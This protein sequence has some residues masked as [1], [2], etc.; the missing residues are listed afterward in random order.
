MQDSRDIYCKEPVPAPHRRRRRSNRQP[1][2]E[3]SGNSR[4]R[5]PTGPVPSRSNRLIIWVVVIGIG[6]VYAAFLVRSLLHNL[7]WGKDANKTTVALNVSPGA[8]VTLET[9]T[10]TQADQWARKSVRLWAQWNGLMREAN[11]LVK[12]GKYDEAINRLEN[13]AANKPFLV[14]INLLLGKL[15]YQ[16]Q[17][18][19]RAQ[20]V[21]MRV[22][23][24]QP[25][26]PTAQMMLATVYSLKRNDAAA[27]A[28]AEWILENQPDSIRAH[29]MAA[30]AYIR[31][32]R[33][34]L[35]MNHLRKLATLEP[36]NVEARNNLGIAYLKLGQVESAIDQLADLARM[37]MANA[38]TYYNLAAAYAGK[39]AGLQA[40][41]CLKQASAAVGPGMVQMWISSSAFDPL[42][43]D[44]LFE[45][46]QRSIEATNRETTA[47]SSHALQAI[48][49]FDVTGDDALAPGTLPGIN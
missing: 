5:P 33:L 3:P 17:D 49:P 43:R 13:V 39:G 4:R 31:T 38:V 37:N 10:D 19:D 27:L 47:A 6:V 11:S 32:D 2:G 15:Y 29:R 20:D 28:L 18:Y 8:Q 16:T 35:A 41:E 1:D 14:E 21:L 46:F 34:N 48:T 23:D 42:R 30:N 44:Q 45:A 26:D 36:H 40:V 22:L 9:L 12:E 24:A 25:Q 7:E